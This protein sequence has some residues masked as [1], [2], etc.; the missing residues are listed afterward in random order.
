M[1]IL[2]IYPEHVKLIER[3]IKKF[4]F[5][6]IFSKKT[7]R[8]LL[9]SKYIVVYETSPKSAITLILVIGEI[10]ENRISSLWENFGCNSG[11]TK[12]YFM[13]YYKK[14]IKG[15]AFEI[16]EFF[17]LDNPISLKDIKRKYKNFTP[18]Q[19]FYNLDEKSYPKLYKE[20]INVIKSK[21]K[22]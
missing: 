3:G 20:L 7:K 15:T 12:E 13:K 19:N 1:I 21:E 2:S 14:D 8:K 10:I 4:E 17:V 5:R 6:K 16:K 11:I 18:P 22:S 9:N